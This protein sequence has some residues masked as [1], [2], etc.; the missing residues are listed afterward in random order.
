MNEKQKKNRVG[1]PSLPNEKRKDIK[2]T[3]RLDK[4]YKEKLEKIAEK[5]RVSLT[6]FIRLAIENYIESLEDE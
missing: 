1:R 3:L 5:E 6:K 2:F 4:E